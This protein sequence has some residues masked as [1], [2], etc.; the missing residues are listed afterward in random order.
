M[1]TNWSHLGEN[2]KTTIIKLLQKPTT[3]SLETQENRRS[4][5]IYKLYKITK[6]NYVAQNPITDNTQTSTNLTYVN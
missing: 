2:F 1:E 4:Q 6:W 3:N 5:Q